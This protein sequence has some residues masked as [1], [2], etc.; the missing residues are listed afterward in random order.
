MIQTTQSFEARAGPPEVHSVD[1]LLRE[2]MQKLMNAAPKRSKELRDECQSSLER[3]D[4][5]ASAAGICGD[6]HFKALK[7]A[8]E[9]T[10][11][12]KVVVVALDCIQKLLAHGFLTGKGPDAFKEAEKGQPPRTL[13]D[14][15]VECIC[16]C[17]EQ[18]DD[19][20][21]LTMVRA[22]LTGVTSQTCEVHGNSLM[23]AVKKSFQ[24]HQDSKNAMNQ[25]T[26]QA[27]LTQMLSVVAQRMELSSADMSRRSVSFEDS[28]NDSSRKQA[29][30]LA[31]S[32]DLALLPPNK[33]LEDWTAS[34]ITR[35]V[36][37]VVLDSR[38]GEKAEPV[39]PGK[40]GWC[41]V[42]RNS[43]AHYCVDTK[44]P[45]CG[46][47]CK[48]RNLERISL[49]ETHY[50]ARRDEEENSK[51]PVDASEDGEVFSACHV[52]LFMHISVCLYSMS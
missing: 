4:S 29:A 33:L 51:P 21:Q 31:S 36:D 47:P 14:S 7:Y 17:Q 50:G 26:A 30:K 38:N 28:Q 35:L 16:N 2:T 5:A 24:I 27:S 12:P 34:Y 20:V 39:P 42:C 15:V 10:G 25:R 11:V 32:R 1:A 37:Q 13:I 40:F 8:C 45:V 52:R 46:H 49:V 3:L 19:T 23:L 9:C 41:V 6:D 43:A 44:D 48:F 18:A 22:L